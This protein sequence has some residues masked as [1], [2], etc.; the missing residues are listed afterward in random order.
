[1]ATLPPKPDV[2]GQVPA[3]QQCAT[4]RRDAA[5]KKV[6]VNLLHQFEFDVVDA[7]PLVEERRFQKDPPRIACSSNPRSCKTRARVQLDRSASTRLAKP[8]TR[9]GAVPQRSAQLSPQR[10]RVGDGALAVT[11]DLAAAVRRQQQPF[12][13]Q[14][15]AVE[16]GE[17]GDRGAA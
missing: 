13:Y 5:A 4:S 7:S 1:M 8:D 10:L 17:P 15:V 9:A 2:N 12:D 16:F 6:V 11:P 14:S 3:R